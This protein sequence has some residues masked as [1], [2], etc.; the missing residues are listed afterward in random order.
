MRSKLAV[1]RQ[2]DVA[3]HA[4]NARFALA[5]SGADLAADSLRPN[6]VAAAGLA[7]LAALD[8]PEALLAEVAAPSDD[9]RVALA[10]TS[11]LVAL[12][13]DGAGRIA[14]AD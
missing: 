1:I 8:V 11:H 9:V 2:A 4:A 13:L 5:L 7:S 14:I 6:R 12:L 10:L 3:L